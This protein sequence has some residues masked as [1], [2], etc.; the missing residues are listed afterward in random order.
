M[1]I[2]FTVKVQ[3]PV[4]YLQNTTENVG[5]RQRVLPGSSRAP[6]QHGLSS[7]IAVSVKFTSTCIWTR[8]GHISS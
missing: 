5:Q 4:Q 8:C 3:N 1:L 2:F 6:T 7:T